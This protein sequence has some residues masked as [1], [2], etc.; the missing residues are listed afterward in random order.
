MA[1]HD[2]V[3]IPLVPAQAGT[4][5]LSKSLDSRFR[6]NER[7]PRARAKLPLERIAGLDV[8]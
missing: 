6:G 4:Q 8:D 5:P 2:G 1:G 3:S 7:L